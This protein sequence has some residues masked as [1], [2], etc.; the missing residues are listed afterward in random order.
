M[1][2][3]NVSALSNAVCLCRGSGQAGK[4]PDASPPGVCEAAEETG[5]Y[6]EEMQSS[7]CPG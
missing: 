5:R 2:M 1:K 3:C 7:G 6:R 4:A